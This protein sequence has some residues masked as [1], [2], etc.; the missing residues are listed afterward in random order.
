[1]RR[2]TLVLTLASS[3]VAV[4]FLAFVDGIGSRRSSSTVEASRGEPR[5]ADQSPSLRTELDESTAQ[6]R[7]SGGKVTEVIP[8]IDQVGDNDTPAKRVSEDEERVRALVREQAAQDIRKIYALPLDDID[9]SPVEKDALI[10]FL[11]EDQIVRTTTRYSPGKNVSERERS[12]GIAAVIGDSKLQ[13][14]L[15]AERNLFS[16]EEVRKIASV[17]DKNEVPLTESQRENL[18]QIIERVGNPNETAP[19][20]ELERSSLEHVEWVLTQ[21]SE[22]ERLLM[23]LAPS[24]LSPKQAVYLDEQY[25]YLSYQRANAIEGKKQSVADHPGEDDVLFWTEWIE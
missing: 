19:P 25:Q 12:N 10:A 14:F 7:S 16:Y 5:S 21:R 24:V 3:A 4:G 6:P 23:E 22:F 15:A 20:S 9:L 18:F 11:I 13:E 2:A 1:M 8:D 17:M